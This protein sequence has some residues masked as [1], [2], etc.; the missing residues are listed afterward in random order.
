MSAAKRFYLATRALTEEDGD[1]ELLKKLNAY[2]AATQKRARA[3]LEKEHPELVQ[4][5]GYANSTTAADGQVLIPDAEFVTEVFENL[6]KY[7]VA[8]ADANVRTTDKT[9]VRVISLDSGL[10]FYKTSEGGVKTSAKLSFSKNEVALDKYAVIVPAA[11][12]FSDDAAIDY[13]NL[14]QQELTRAYA[15]TAD[16]VV[17]TDPV[18]SADGS[19]GITNQTGVLT[20]TIGASMDWDDFLVAE[21]KT[22]DDLDESDNK[23]YMRKETW[24]ALIMTKG[25]TND[26]YIAGSLIPNWAPNPTT[27]TTPW[28]RRVRFTRVLPTINSVSAND[29]F[30]V[31]GDL[32]NYLLYQKRGM[33]L[34]LMTEATIHDSEG[35]QVNLGEQDISAMRAVIRLLGILP[36]GNRTKFVV[37]GKGTV[38]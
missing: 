19:G 21:S 3:K 28:G 17:F 2:A 27:P 26:H 9:A 1:K 20:H 12:E 32:K 35:V 34:K 11:D 14:V 23:W 31:F 8:F 25:T 33:A 16:E 36:K 7:G 37:M 15:R 30:A 4:R 29:A 38:S 10:R 5:T 13:W 24:F 6:P 18:G 22:E